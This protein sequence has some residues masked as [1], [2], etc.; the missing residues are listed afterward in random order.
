MVERFSGSKASQKHRYRTIGAPAR[1]VVDDEQ[2]E[3]AK[4]VSP[5][6]EEILHSEEWP[7]WEFGW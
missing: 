6:L 2:A 7:P 1:V 4:I 5:E 3:L